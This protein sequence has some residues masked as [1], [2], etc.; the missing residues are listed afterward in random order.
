MPHVAR[1][2]TETEVMKI[3]QGKVRGF[4]LIEL[5]VTVAIVGI[6]AAIAYPSYLSQIL[7]GHRAGAESYLM[8]LAQRQ[9]QYFTDTRS[10]A[11]DVATLNDPVPSEIVNYYTVQIATGATPPTFVITAT[12][13]G[14]QVSD[15]NLTIDNTGAKTPTNLW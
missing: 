6:L 11:P 13:I 7:K 4:T 2:F 10:Y 9:Q 3:G 15:G 8:A 12:A 14:G 1:D 5:M